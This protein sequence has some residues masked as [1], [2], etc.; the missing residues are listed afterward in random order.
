MRITVPYHTLLLVAARIHSETARV[1]SQTH[2]ISARQSGKRELQ[3]LIALER[4]LANGRP[5]PALL[6]DFARAPAPRATKSR[7]QTPYKSRDGS[8]P[9]WETRRR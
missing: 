3:E 8:P 1:V 6:R 2:E 5:T 9:V 7:G 4:Q